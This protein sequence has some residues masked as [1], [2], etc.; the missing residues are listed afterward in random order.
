[1]DSLYQDTKTTENTPVLEENMEPLTQGLAKVA[2][3]S[4]KPSLFDASPSS[5]APNAMKKRSKRGEAPILSE[6][7]VRHSSRLHGVNKG[8]KPSSCKDK[9]C[10]GCVTK[11][12]LMS[13]V[14]ELATTFCKLSDSE[15]TDEKLMANPTKKRVVGRPKKDKDAKNHKDHNAQ[16][17]KGASG[18]GIDA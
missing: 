11:P 2:E 7:E 12:P 1:M 8:F 14:R 17:P 10:V 6:S 3:P 9:N 5:A 15:L 16:D 13:V 4:A 18:E